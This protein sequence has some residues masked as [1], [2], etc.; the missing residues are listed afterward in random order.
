MF[1]ACTPL[2]VLPVAA[3]EENESTESIAQGE[4]GE[5]PPAEEES[6]NDEGGDKSKKKQ[7]VGEIGLRTRPG[8]N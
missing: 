6:S 3:V 1:A 5:E 4:S 8:Q 7:T 2:E